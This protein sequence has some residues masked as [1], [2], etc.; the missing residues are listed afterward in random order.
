MKRLNIVL[1]I[2]ALGIAACKGKNS[3]EKDYFSIDWALSVSANPG[4]AGKENDAESKL[5]AEE[6]RRQGFALY[7]Q[8]R[9]A[10]AILKYQA[11]LDLYTDDAIYFDYANSL[12]NIEGRLHDSI[13]AYRVGI[14]I[15]RNPSANLYYNL[16]CAQSRAGEP[17]AAIE[18]LRYA[19][20][21]GKEMSAIESDSDL[22]KVRELTDWRALALDPV[23][24]PAGKAMMMAAGGGSIREFFC[25]NPGD[26]SG[27]AVYREDFYGQYNLTKEGE[28]SLEGHSVRVHYTNE[29]GENGTGPSTPGPRGPTYSKFAPFERVINEKKTIDSSSF[30]SYPYLDISGPCPD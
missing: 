27:R 1:L 19:L 30:N 26:K 28:W 23:I 15:S 11:A 20:K 24:T 29:K 2:L 3:L 8:K 21:K 9:D 18:N 5:K 12:S 13:K 17:L 10:D 4:G 16:A 7:R 22:A 25:G 14:A 6:F